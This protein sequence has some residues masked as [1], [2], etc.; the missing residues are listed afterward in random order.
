MNDNGIS[1]I[2]TTV[3][4]VAAVLILAALAV[5]AVV[6]LE[7][8][9]D[10]DDV[11]T[12]VIY[13]YDS[14]E[15]WGLAD[16][17]IP[18][19][20]E[21]Y[22]INVT[23]RTMG[24]AGN[25]MARL[26]I[27]KEDPVA[28]LVIGIDNSMLH[29]AKDLN[30][31]ETYKPDGLSSVDPELVFDPEGYLTPYDYGYIAIICNGEMMEDLS[32]PYPDSIL[33]L[34]DPVYEDSIMFIDPV[35]S[36]TGSSFLIWASAVAEGDRSSFFSDLS[37]NSFNV[38]GTWDA[39]YAAFQAGE[40]PIAISYGLDTASEMM[41]AE[42]PDSVTTVT[43]VP[44][45]EGYRQMEGAGIV[46]DAGNR[47]AAEDF[48]DFMLTPAF[49]EKVGYNVMLPVVDGTPVDQI[50]LDNGEFAGSH[51]EPDQETIDENWET[52]LSD[53]EQAFS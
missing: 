34:A 28:D 49:Q 39:M 45:E 11:N 17:V 7:S 5:S 1:A 22:G 42:D 2:R 24:D 15:S 50:Y 41:W 4:I 16:A 6:Y 52:W 53:W 3:S 14:F 36:S 13:S 8:R 35:T 19:F 38:Y 26:A 23:L 32:L 46:N 51:V 12:L 9:D 25:V 44:D 37:S 21:E 29:K 43:I 30:L 27:E 10:D 40:A 48:L 33:D 18:V 20:E 47:D 31:L